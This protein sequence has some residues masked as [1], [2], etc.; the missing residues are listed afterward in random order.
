[1]IVIAVAV[2]AV[3]TVIA[4]AAAVVTV[5]AAVT[6]IETSAA[7]SSLAACLYSSCYK[8]KFDFGLFW[9]LVGT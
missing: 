2:A 3:A 6:A 9:L 1:V 5:A 8:P 4:V 7:K